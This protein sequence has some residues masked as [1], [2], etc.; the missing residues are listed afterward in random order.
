MNAHSSMSMT[1]SAVAKVGC[2]VTPDDGFAKPVPESRAFGRA[3]AV[4]LLISCVS[5]LG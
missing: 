2:S 1:R 4:L 3:G 5:R